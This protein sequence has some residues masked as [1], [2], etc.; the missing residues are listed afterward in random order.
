MFDIYL[1]AYN[2]NYYCYDINKLAIYIISE[3]QYEL[4]NL[5]YLGPKMIVKKLKDKY[6]VKAIMEQIVYVDS[7]KKENKL[8]LKAPGGMVYDHSNV[9]SLECI[10]CTNMSDQVNVTVDVIKRKFLNSGISIKSIDN[11]IFLS[12]RKIKKYDNKESDCLLLLDNYLGMWRDKCNFSIE[13][14]D[15][16]FYTELLMNMNK[17]ISNVSQLISSAAYMN[18][19]T[20]INYYLNLLKA[21]KKNIFPCFAGIKH[22]FIDFS[23]DI[24]LCSNEIQKNNILN[25]DKLPTVDS[26]YTLNSCYN[27]SVRF[28]CGGFCQPMIEKA[29]K[30]CSIFIEI[31]IIL[32]KVYI[33]NNKVERI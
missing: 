17:D 3:L 2:E 13:D 19:I 14:K 8:S 10:Y 25:I 18:K 11:D 23:G 30:G 16:T 33:H 31:I 27:C 21:K 20:N 28:F 22:L 15:R 7:M 12:N 24:H 1:F 9:V 6:P 4:L 32:L 26:V 5:Y 29:F